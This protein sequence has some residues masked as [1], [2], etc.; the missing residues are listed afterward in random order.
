MGLVAVVVGAAALLIRIEG[1]IRLGDE[2]GRTEHAYYTL[3]ELAQPVLL[4]AFAV[5]LGAAVV[6]VVRQRLVAGILLFVYW[7]VVWVYWLFNSPVLR[8]LTPLQVPPVPVDVGPASTSPASF[9]QEWLLSTP[10]EYQE[11]WVRLV[12]SPSLAAWHDVY[13]VALTLL[14]VAVAVPG[15]VRRACA[16][17]GAVLAVGAVLMQAV[18]NP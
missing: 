4:A 7:F 17:A 10:G 8:W 16:V 15:R 3:P 11:Q 1:G 6:H 9:P 2:P 13:L 12:V 18:V 14:A 5:A